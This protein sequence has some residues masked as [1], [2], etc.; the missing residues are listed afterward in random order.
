[1]L[2]SR[3][4]ISQQQLDEALAA[5]RRIGGRLGTNLVE[6]G[7]IDDGRLAACLSEQLDVPFVR[8]SA[9][10]SVPGEVINLMPRSLAQKYRAVPFRASGG[11]LHV[12]MADPQ[13]FERV[14]EMAFALNMR[15][16]P[17]VVTEVTLNYALER[18][19]N[20]HRERRLAP[21][22]TGWPELQ[23]GGAG[24][25]ASTGYTGSFQVPVM[26]P[27]RTTTASL[28]AVTDAAA[29][30]PDDQTLAQ[31]SAV[32]TDEDVAQVVFQYMT[33]VFEEV[34]VLAVSE[35]YLEL[36]AAGNRHRKRPASPTDVFSLSE[37][38]ITG[39]LAK[40]QVLHQARTSDPGLRK[41]CSNFGLPVTNL[42]LI[43]LFTDA[44]PRHV[45]IALGL[46]QTALVARFAQLKAF[47]GK[48]A[49]ALRIVALRQEILRY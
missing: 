21:G 22:V 27:T 38:V 34:L 2:I 48:V 24:G 29:A 9:L 36:E 32:M 12:C 10:A 1:M 42:T 19:F 8:P 20:V 18:Y 46:D 11:E 5:Q 45:V 37:G 4:L 13:N 31:L 30:G 7:F 14:D 49:H 39:L 35:Q 17:Y 3:G 47:L 44:R 23:L 25:G 41:L 28:P 26:P 43:S 16:R 40:P 15:L 6:L 33:E